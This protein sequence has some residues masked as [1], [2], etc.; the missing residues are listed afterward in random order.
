MAGVGLESRRDIWM[1][2]L[3]SSSSL[4]LTV[5]YGEKVGEE[6][7]ETIIAGVQSPTIVIYRMTAI[8]CISGWL[9]LSYARSFN[10][11]KPYIEWTLLQSIHSTALESLF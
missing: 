9:S 4:E 8:L 6:E 7:R 1:A 10:T 11:Q 3:M 2:L 5:D